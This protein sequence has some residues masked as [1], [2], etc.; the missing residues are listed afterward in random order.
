MRG[1]IHV[2]PGIC[3]GRIS[4]YLAYCTVEGCMNTVAIQ[5][6]TRYSMVKLKEISVGN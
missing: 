6:K 2:E 3:D 1:S 4:S 5:Q